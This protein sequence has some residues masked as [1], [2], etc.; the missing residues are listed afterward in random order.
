[1]DKISSR[2]LKDSLPSTLTTITRIVNNSFVTNTFAR[3]GKQQESHL[4]SN[5]VTKMPLTIT[6]LSHYCQ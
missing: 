6:A 5:A 2:I 4:F 1:M 3:R